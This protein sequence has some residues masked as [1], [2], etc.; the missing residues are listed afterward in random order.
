MKNSVLLFVTSFLI[1]LSSVLFA[2]STTIENINS[3]PSK[4]EGNQVEVEGL[5]TQY[6]HD[7]GTTSYYLIKGD[8]GGIIRV[9]T[10]EPAPETNQKYHVKGIVYIN[11][12]K[13]T[14]F[15][16]EKTKFILTSR[17]NEVVIRD[18]TIN[19]PPQVTVSNDNSLIYILIGFLLILI[20]VFAYFQFNKRK[21]PQ[22]D[23]KGFGQ[24]FNPPNYTPAQKY[25]DH[26][27]TFSTESDYK[28]IK[29]VTSN[30]KTL[31]FIPGKLVISDG[32]DKG[33]EFRV[34]GY[35]TPDG[36]IVSIGR[37]E[38][39]G[40]RAYA[41]IQLKEMTV[42]RDQAELVH[43]NGKL[44]L[45]NLSETNLTQLNGEELNVGQVKEVTPGSKIR[46]GE[47]EFQYII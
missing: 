2:Q 13:G 43:R 10:A 3:N 36:F 20:G 23:Q 17:S 39:N 7:K 19:P 14:P 25:E 4:Y 24:N 35:P 28:T 15:I 1:I 45:K 30:P 12:N 9:N 6:V 44:M 5:V 32:K 21:E 34:A 29:I 22:F 26:P 42:S 40:E 47:V 46:T 8:F 41:H 31:K 11:Q 37:K 16:S 33:K 18:T 27:P 38:V